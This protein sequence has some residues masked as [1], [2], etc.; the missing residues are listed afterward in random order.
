MISEPFN[1]SVAELV[2]RGPEDIPAPFIPACHLIYSSPAT[3][4][5]NSPGAVGFGVKR[6]GLVIPESV[7]LLVSPSA[8]GRNSSILSSE[9]GYADRMFYYCMD[10]TD[11]VTGRHLTEIPEAISQIV[12]ICD[13]KPK[14]VV[15][16]I[17]CVDALL[18][19]DL[20]RVCRK[21]EAETGVLVV[22]SYMYAL[23]REGKKPPMVAIRDTIYSLLT[24]KP[25]EPTTVNLMGFFSPL[26]ENSELFSLLREAGIRTINQVSR[27]QTLDEYYEL[28]AANFNIVLHPESV[29]AAEQLYARTG[30]PFVELTRLY[31]P[32]RIHKLYRLFASAVGITY[33]DA[34][35]YEEA[36]RV[37][38]DFIRKHKGTSFAIGEMTNANPYELAATL[39]EMGMHVP[40]LFSNLTEADYPYLRRLAA[41][42]PDTRVYT[43]IDPSMIHYE[44]VSGVDLAIGKDAAVY[45][46]DAASVEWNSECQPFGFHGFTG[47]MN[48]LDRA[49]SD[50]EGTE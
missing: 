11:L 33:N 4:S 28:G 32:E 23:T 46:P 30:M 17:T 34:P 5:Y 50:K 47:L 29:F 42:S 41:V 21:A 49:L 25:V 45:C 14:A 18:G 44:P 37:R 24:R 31:D 40:Y 2:A 27:C 48:E 8:C 9:E 26:D 22:P 20:E 1:I 12:E 3:L 38:D 7:M 6:A 35:Y 16:C 36:C 15:I 13:P 43:G 39:C 10:E 19:T